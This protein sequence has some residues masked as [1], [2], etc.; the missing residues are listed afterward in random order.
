M[1]RKLL[2]KAS[3]A[4]ALIAGLA[5]CD[6]SSSALAPRGGADATR[7][8]R[9]VTPTDSLGRRGTTTSTTMSLDDDSTCRTGYQIAYR[10]DGSSYC[11]PIGGG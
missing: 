10:D 3:A 4:L 5:A 7:A 2:L 1:S 11:E 9:A 6:A 8:T